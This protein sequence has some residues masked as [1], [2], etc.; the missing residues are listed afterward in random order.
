MPQLA[1]ERKLFSPA[2]PLIFALDTGISSRLY[3]ACVVDQTSNN[4]VLRIG[5]LARLTGVSVDTLR[6]YE[7]KGL[8]KAQRLSNGYRVYPAP[9]VERV[10]LVQ[11]ALAFGFTLDEL[12]RVFQVRDGGGAPCQQVLALTATK[13]AEL[14]QRLREMTALRD[15]LRALLP[16]WEARVQA[17]APDQPACLLDDLSA[18]SLRQGERRTRPASAWPTRNAKRKEKPT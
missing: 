12:A 5:E 6:H 1:K 18:T 8:L 7:R 16:G 11:G 15:D 9:A 14:E 10:R 13:L 4:E 3:S 17:T 2:I